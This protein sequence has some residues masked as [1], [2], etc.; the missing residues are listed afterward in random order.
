MCLP[1]LLKISILE[2][3][4]GVALLAALVQ[5]VWFVARKTKKMAKNNTKTRNE[6]I[7]AINI[8]S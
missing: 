7:E 5:Y 6:C 1:F 2:L 8:T 4:V 3:S